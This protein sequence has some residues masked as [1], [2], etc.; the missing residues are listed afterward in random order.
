MD[1]KA[2]L[3][4]EADDFSR[5]DDLPRLGPRTQLLQQKL[6]LLDYGRWLAELA[7]TRGPGPATTNFLARYP[8]SPGAVLLQQKAAVAPGTS[9]DATWAGPLASPSAMDEAFLKLVRSA[10]LLGRIPGLR[11]IPSNVKVPLQSVGA[12]YQWVPENGYKPA[13][14]LGFTTGVTLAPLKHAAVTVLTKE[15]V[16][17]ARA[18]FPGALIEALEADLTNF[19]DTQFLDPTITAIAG[20]RPASVTNG[21]T[22]VTSTGVYAT[23]VQSLLTAYFAANPRTPVLITNPAHASAIRSLNGGGGLG[24]AVIDTTAAGGITVALDPSG[25][26]I[27]DSGIKV[28]RSEQ[29]SLQMD[30]VPTSPPTASTVQVSL[31]QTNAVGYLVERFVNWQATANSVKYLAP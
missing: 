26:F 16:T 19:T 29:A 30:S 1:T 15:L 3:A 13:S 11:K 31:W 10:S 6:L 28:E 22:A 25:V 5:L 14:A 2:L 23:D 24:V 9:T 12:V 4:L 20:A 7:E 17:A 8:R 21:T 18:G 27:S